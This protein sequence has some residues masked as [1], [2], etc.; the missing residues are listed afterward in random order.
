MYKK[1]LFLLVLFWITGAFSVFAENT[2]DMLLFYS[3]IDDSYETQVK[4]LVKTRLDEYKRFAG[5]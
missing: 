1:A 5:F 2:D 4:G 3:K